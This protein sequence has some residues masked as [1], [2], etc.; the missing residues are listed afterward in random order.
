MISGINHITLSVRDLE[1]SFTFYTTVLGL[2]PVARWF[3]G[4]YL[5]AAEDWVCLT[6]DPN[7]RTAAHPEYTHTA[8]TVSAADYSRLVERLRAAQAVCW[9]E[10]RS[11]GDSF[12]FLD[13]D[14]HKLEIHVSNLSDRLQTLKAHPPKDLIFFD[15]PAK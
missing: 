3:K 13:P 1:A 11:H 6:L 15:E 10:N 7:T 5:Q 2:K 8:F 9:Q 4:T 12:Y 14:G